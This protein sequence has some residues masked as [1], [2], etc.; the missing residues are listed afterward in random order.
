MTSIAS[1]IKS[2]R[3]T[4][5]QDPGAS[6]DTQRLPQISWMLFLKIYDVRESDWEF[7][8]KNYKSIIPEEYRWRN[9]ATDTEDGKALGKALTGKELLDFVNNGLLPT[10]KNLNV[11]PETEERQLIVKRM[12]AN[13]INYVQNGTTLRKIINIID[14]INFDDYKEEHAFNTIYE[15]IL[16][17]MQGSKATG[18]F[19]TPRAVTD[20]VVEMVNPKLGEKIADLGCGTGGFLVSALNHLKQQKNRIEDLAIYQN[21]IYGCEWKDLPFQMCMTNLLSHGIDAP[22]L[23]Q[24]DSLARDV[25]EYTEDEKFDVIV[26]NPPYGGNT[27]AGTLSNFP[28]NMRTSETAFLF[29]VLL[30][31]RLKMNGRVGIVVSDGFLNPSSD[32]ER[33]IIKK[34][35]TECNLHTV[36]RLP[37]SVFSPYTPIA[38]N[39]L[40]FEKTG[41]TKET[42]FYRLDM[43]EDRLH[44]SKTKPIQPQHFDCVREWWS[45]KTEIQ[46]EQE[47][48]SLPVSFKAK[49]Y[50]IDEFV[51]RKYNL[52]LCGYPHPVEI[53]LRPDELFAEYEEKKAKSEEKIETILNKIKDG[54]RAK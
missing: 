5:W 26:M 45:N 2:I 23:I 6:S 33:E 25:T 18:E 36:I 38:T 7:K 15:S 32:N 29:T 49:K 17:M 1:F 39:L 12:F 44:F 30:L 22:N 3:Q 42:W 8:D 35:L 11:T 46:D 40:F 43:P 28:I 9:W 54:L 50:S 14:G 47:D 16:K 4:M 20:F 51:S 52:D 24:G 10:L 34:L 41:K 27:E 13:T 31:Y 48:E 21:S 37:P 19:Y 53:V